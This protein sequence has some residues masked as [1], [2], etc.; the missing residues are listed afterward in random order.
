[1]D[2]K[3]KAMKFAEQVREREQKAKNKGKDLLEK[4][5]S[6]DADNHLKINPE[7]EELLLN[8]PKRLE[9]L[10]Y[11][12]SKAE[13]REKVEQSQKATRLR[14]ELVKKIQELAESNNLGEIDAEISAYQENLKGINTDEQGADLLEP[15]TEEAVIAELQGLSESVETGYSLSEDVK[16]AFPA[17][18]ITAVVAPTG[19]GKTRALINFSLGVLKE[20]PD[21]SVYFFTYEENRA[22]ILT[23][24]LNTYINEELSKN[25]R[26]SI[27]QYF[28]NRGADRFKY[29]IKDKSIPVSEGESQSLS[30]YFE[31]KKDKFF[32][33]VLSP[34][35]LNIIY[36]EHD[37]DQLLQIIQELKVKKED[38]GLICIDYI[39]L[40][41]DR[42]GKTPFFSRLH[43][44]KIGE[45]GD[46]ERIANLIIGIFDN[47]EESKLHI[48]ILKGREIGAGQRANF[49]YN[50][51]S[52]KIENAEPGIF[53][54]L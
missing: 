12:L 32:A 13:K 31:E 6:K 20:N 47:R 15:L 38:L 48:E 29:F 11:L 46:I 43:P 33:E 14:V 28:K 26:A 18:A 50:G 22:A 4:L 24:F 23:L 39:Q 27:K 10:R 34:G 44:T 36:C 51:N 16:V 53:E 52:G 7:L 45:A 37:V 54:G 41:N 25:N 3:E 2:A 1:M 5:F 35:R 19:H 30:A 21:K 42:T 40:L 8:D 17:G 49:G 9:Q